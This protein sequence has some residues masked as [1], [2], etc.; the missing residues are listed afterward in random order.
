MTELRGLTVRQPWAWAIA[1]GGKDVENRTWTTRWRGRLLIHAG[2]ALDEWGHHEQRVLAAWQALHGRPL[3]YRT[4]AQLPRAA[5]VA[6]ADLV[7]VHPASGACCLSPWGQRWQDDTAER[8]G[9]HHWVLADVHQL[10]E[11]I[12]AR[13]RQGLWHPTPELASLVTPA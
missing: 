3:D 7:D 9:I 11:P 6:T 8:G 12:P 1:A 5:V 4:L 13:G 2:T 10:P